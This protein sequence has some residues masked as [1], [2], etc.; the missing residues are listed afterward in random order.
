MYIT[1]QLFTLIY[2]EHI[3]FIFKLPTKK[4]ALADAQAS[5][6]VVFEILLQI[7]M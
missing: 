1:F 2:H 6:L 3:Y 5:Y 4:V 7:F